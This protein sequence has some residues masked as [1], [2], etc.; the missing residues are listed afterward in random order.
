MDDADTIVK[1]LLQEYEVSYQSALLYSRQK[2]TVW[3]I[4][5]GL[6]VSVYTLYLNTRFVEIEVLKGLSASIEVWTFVGIPIA[7]MGFQAFYYNRDLQQA[8]SCECIEFIEEIFNEAFDADFMVWRKIYNQRMLRTRFF[9]EHRSS[10]MVIDIFIAGPLIAL[11]GFSIYKAFFLIEPSYRWLF[12][13]IFGVGPAFAM[14]FWLRSHASLK[15][16]VKAFKSSAIPKV[17]SKIRQEKFSN[18][19]RYNEG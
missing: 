17:A 3:K 19:P 16:R 6:L 1:I 2:E 7:L 9:G 8:A 14:W 18:D 15:K 10:I 11:Q 4:L 5:L 13:L 12:V